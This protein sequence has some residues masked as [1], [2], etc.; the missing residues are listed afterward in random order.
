MS[1]LLL[2]VRDGLTIA[3]PPAL[4]A[5]TTYV[6]LEQE[7]W[8]EKETHFLRHFLKPGMTAIDIGANLGVYSLLMA[9]LVGPGGRVF[10]YE[11]GSEARAF[12][13]RSRE[14]NDLKNLEISASALS[15]SD[16][17]GHLAFAASSEMRA[18][19]AAGT[20]EPVHIT[21]LDAEGAA[22]GWGSPD[23]IKIDAEGEEERIIAGGRDFFSTC[24][25]LVMFEVQT[26]KVN[27]Q[28]LP[29]FPA[30]GYRLFR[31][32][33]GAPILVP[34]EVTQP[35]YRYEL[36]LFAAKPDRVNALSQQGLLV[37]AIPDWVPSEDDRKNAVSFW[38]GQ[39][40]ASSTA[41]FDASRMSAT[42]DYQNSLAAYAAWRAVDQPATTRCAALAFAFKSLF[43]L[44]A[45][46]WTP[47]RASTLA[48]V[49]W[50]WGARGESVSALGHLL[51]NLRSTGIYFREPFWPASPRFDDVSPGTQLV[52]WFAAAAAEQFERT[53]SFS[54]LFNGAS[55]ALQWLCG[56]PFASAEM[57]RRRTLL[58][59]V[60]GQRPRVPE[61]L[62]T[63]AQDHLNADVWRGG[64]V[65]GTVVGA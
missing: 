41:A 64:M 33:A 23:F 36:N 31:L 1:A 28:L 15:D 58:A 17:E 14:L 10:S 8:F 49:A 34:Q 51:E 3:V 13:E 21:S 47:E 22:R 7:D 25:P 35:L 2:R 61:R 11:P 9:R 46:E 42:L 55:P 59:A 65:P 29:I 62:C 53:C 44:C 18:L 40:F 54:S 63:A 43:A 5:V 37:D 52:E 60:S 57:E 26:D 19:G 48:R 6:L 24:S 16:R 12:L 50:E 45:A 39:K 32:L 56:Q 30:L 20:G 4:T 38:H 27:D